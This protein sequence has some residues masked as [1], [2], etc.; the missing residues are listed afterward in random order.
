MSDTSTGYEGPRGATPREFG[1]ILDFVNYVFRA[2]QGRRPSMGG[3]YPHCYR[4]ANAE[5]FRHIRHDGHVVSCVNIYRAE[6]CWDDATLVVGAIGGVATDP[7]HRRGGLAGE[8]LEDAVDYMTTNRYD[9]SILWTGIGDYYRRWGWEDAGDRWRIDMDR[10]TLAYLPATPVGE[11][12]TKHDDER[13]IEGIRILHTQE[14]RGV[15]RDRDLTEAMLGNRIHFRMA[16]QVVNN[17][18]VAYILYGHTDNVVVECG[19]DPDG[20][21][22]LMRTTFTEQDAQSA[23]LLLPSEH[24]ELTGRLTDLGFRV[25]VATQGM[26]MIINPANTLRAYGI[27]DMSFKREPSD[28]KKSDD[29][30]VMY[31]GEEYRYTANNLT[32]LLFGPEQPDG[33][34]HPKLPLPFHYGQTDHM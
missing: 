16:L 14:G 20:I 30:V 18:P 25:K 8:N 33:L 3:D 4:E 24:T 1:E 22:G 6:T 13:V 21:L 10:T 12:L 27:D 29:W 26:I 23:T 17:E 19:G 32:K 9:I 28:D 15:K 5:L 7:E 11:I 2:D 34:K 31:N